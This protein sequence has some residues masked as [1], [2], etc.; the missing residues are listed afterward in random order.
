[1]DVSSITYN[2]LDNFTAKPFVIYIEKFS[3]TFQCSTHS[4]LE[5]LPS[6]DNSNPLQIQ[7]GRVTRGQGEYLV[8]HQLPN[9]EKKQLSKE[10]F[11]QVHPIL[12]RYSLPS[13]MK[14][15]SE[16]A[17]EQYV[18]RYELI[19]EELKKLDESLSIVFVPRALYELVF[20]RKCIKEDLKHNE[21]CPFLLEK[22]QKQLDDTAKDIEE[23]KSSIRAKGRE[24]CWHLARFKGLTSHPEVVKDIAY[25]LN[26][27]LVKTL[28]PNQEGMTR[29]EI[30]D[31]VKD[32][33]AFLHNHYIKGQKDIEQAKGVDGEVDFGKISFLKDNVPYS[34]FPYSWDD[35]YT[36]VKVYPFMS[37]EPN[38]GP[39]VYF[40]YDIKL[41]EK[42]FPMC[43]KTDADAQI[44]RNVV[45]LECSEMAKDTIFLYRG[46]N[47]EED[48][49]LKYGRLHSLSYGTGLFSGQNDVGAMPFH[50]MLNYKDGYAIPVR[51]DQLNHCPFFVPASDTISQLLSEGEFFHARSMAYQDY[52]PHKMSGI[53]VS[54]E[55]NRDHLI[56]SLSKEEF[57]QQFKA[58]QQRAIILK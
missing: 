16:S 37:C 41:T 56:S 43:I 42:T 48:S 15:D 49:L 58:Y 24:K 47:K 44:I 36:E 38:L 34:T 2:P 50:Y 23:R 5:M 25:R 26:K 19:K 22:N 29:L 46:S 21:R 10:L 12:N 4:F 31:F 11:D 45:T 6:V 7:Q 30:L 40:G 3:G 9:G 51:F 54:S 52:D 55:N 27:V 18:N 13:L 8:F 1:M 35:D 32:E 33:T 14:S 39:T 28:Q 17:T 57:T 20:I 53:A